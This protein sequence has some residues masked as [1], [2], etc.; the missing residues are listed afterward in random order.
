MAKIVLG[1]NKS[2][3]APAILQKREVI[4]S[5][6]PQY[7]IDNTGKLIIDPTQTTFSSYPLTSVGGY[8]W[9]NLFR[10]NAYLTTADLSSIKTFPESNCC[11]YAFAYTQSLVNVDLSSLESIVGADTCSSMFAYCTSLTSIILPSLTTINGNSACSSMFA[12]C[13][14]LI[15]ASFPELTT[16]RAYSN[17]GQVTNYIFNGCTKLTTVSFPKL[18][19]IECL[20]GSMSS[21]QPFR[22]CSALENLS[23]GGLTSTTF[24][25]KVDQLKYLFDSNTGKNAPNGCTLHFPSNFDPS[26]PNHTFDVSTLTGYPTFGGDAN[27]IHLAFDLPATE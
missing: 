8:I 9:N 13:T 1:T 15:T 27:Y 12:Y 14:N 21:S 3:S 7:I 25:T 22:G 2:V 16:L 17:T 20:L 24:S 18:N 23:F 19:T 11:T 26:N 4:P 5:Y 6:L 10:Y